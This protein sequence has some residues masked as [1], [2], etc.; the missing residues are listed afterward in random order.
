[1]N[2]ILYQISFIAQYSTDVFIMYKNEL[3]YMK[4]MF[5]FRFTDAP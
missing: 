2:I 3:P 5:G 4:K 1:M